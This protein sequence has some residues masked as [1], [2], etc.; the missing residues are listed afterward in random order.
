MKKGKRVLLGY[1]AVAQSRIARNLG[2]EGLTLP[3]TLA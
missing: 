3:L 1:L 2:L